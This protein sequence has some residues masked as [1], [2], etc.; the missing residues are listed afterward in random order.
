[1]LAGPASA[2]DL[3]ASAGNV[4]ELQASLE[5]YE[6]ELNDR[7]NLL[8]QEI[9]RRRNI[10]SIQGYHQADSYMKPAILRSIAAEMAFEHMRRKYEDE[11]KAKAAELGRDI[12]TRNA[13]DGQTQYIRFGDREFENCYDENMCALPANAPYYSLHIQETIR[14]GSRAAND[15]NLFYKKD[16]PSLPAGNN[17]IT[18][19]LNLITRYETRGQNSYASIFLDMAE[20]VED[21]SMFRQI[22]ADKV[23]YKQQ[24][25]TLDG[26]GGWIEPTYRI[27]GYEYNSN[28]GTWKTK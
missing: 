12:G 7:Q 15:R 20:T 23:R 22:Q 18:I 14:S 9:R 1:L 19:N 28:A 21:L 4:E 8:E 6:R 27:T 16:D 11:I 17:S 24:N 13:S 26:S 2:E 10:T 3:P 5:T 25:G